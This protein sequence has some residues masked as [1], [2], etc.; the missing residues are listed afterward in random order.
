M[1]KFYSSLNQHDELLDA[2][3]QS[4]I[5]VN[6]PGKESVYVICQEDADLLLAVESRGNEDERSR[7]LN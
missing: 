4:I 1:E 7:M 2:V 6:L 3:E 5:T